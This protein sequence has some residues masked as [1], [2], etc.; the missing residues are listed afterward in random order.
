MLKTTYLVIDAN[1]YDIS[2]TILMNKKKK[3]VSKGTPMNN[4]NPPIWYFSTLVYIKKPVNRMSKIYK[5]DRLNTKAEQNWSA[6]F[7]IFE[8]NKCN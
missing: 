5:I 4:N 8:L 3:N 7:R 1:G 6:I 2:E